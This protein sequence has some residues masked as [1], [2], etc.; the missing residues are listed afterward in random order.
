MVKQWPCL[1]RWRFVATPERLP[2]LRGVMR[3]A[4]VDVIV[5]REDVELAVT[6]AVTNVVRHAYPDG[7]GETLVAVTLRGERLVVAVRD[8]GVGVGAFGES[9]NPGAGLGLRLIEALAGNARIAPRE[10]GTLV[11]MRFSVGA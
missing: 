3:L 5:D 7:V 4:L 9:P 6:E 10:S 8:F 11:V 1:G 2:W